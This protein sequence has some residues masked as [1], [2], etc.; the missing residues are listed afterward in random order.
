MTKRERNFVEELLQIEGA[1]T[2]KAKNFT[3]LSTGNAALN[4]ALSGSI[5]K[6][7][8]LGCLVEVF[9]AD[10]SGKSTLAYSLIN[11][12]LKRNFLAV[13]IDVEGSFTPFQVLRNRIVDANRIVFCKYKDLRRVLKFI[14]TLG[15]KGS[16]KNVKGLIVWDSYAATRLSEKEDSGSIAE[17]VRVMSAALKKF[18]SIFPQSDITLLIINQLRENLR[19]VSFLTSYTQPGGWALKHASHLR[20]EL[21][22]ASSNSKLTR[23]VSDEEGRVIT[24]SVVKSKFYLPTSTDFILLYRHGIDWEYSLIAE[25]FRRGI[26]EFE[27]GWFSFDG[28]KYRRVDLLHALKND[29][30]MRQTLENMLEPSGV[31]PEEV[32]KDEVSECNSKPVD[33]ESG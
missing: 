28:K 25:A 10:G 16:E 29:E 12:A 20:V 23:I 14:E 13:L 17:E 31:K 6:G 11:E 19:G 24:F 9:G 30:G 7:I 2:Y 32:E 27:G 1:D 5:Y 18:L 4:Y 26:L 15:I 3:Y 21:K 22:K 33:L 8:P